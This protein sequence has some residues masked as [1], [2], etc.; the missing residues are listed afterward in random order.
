MQP[1][2]WEAGGILLPF[3]PIITSRA[4]Y[5]GA[6][7]FGVDGVLWGVVGGGGKGGSYGC[8][9]LIEYSL[10]FMRAWVHCLHVEED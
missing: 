9:S 7:P 6:L 8:F 3:P 2:R 1:D 10:H 5:N 4:G